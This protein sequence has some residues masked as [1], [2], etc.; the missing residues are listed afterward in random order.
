VFIKVLNDLVDLGH[1]Y[2]ERFQNVFTDKGPTAVSGEELRLAIENTRILPKP[3]VPTAADRVR[4]SNVAKLFF[5]NK[6]IDRAIS[7]DEIVFDIDE[8]VGRK[9]LEP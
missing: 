1:R 9:G 2:P 3:R 5:V 7:A 8:A 4:V 6:S